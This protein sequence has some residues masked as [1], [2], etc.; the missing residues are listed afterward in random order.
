MKRHPGERVRRGGV[1]GIGVDYL[2]G[3]AS[4]G[5]SGD[6]FVGDGRHVGVGY[7]LD[8]VNAGGQDEPFGEGVHF[9]AETVG[10]LAPVKP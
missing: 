9:F 6:V 8:A 3:E 7:I 4:D 2:G 5:A 10:G 1:G